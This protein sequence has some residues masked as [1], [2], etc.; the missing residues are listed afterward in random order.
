MLIALQNSKIPVL[1]ATHFWQGVAGTVAV[2]TFIAGFLAKPLMRRITKKIQERQLHDLFIDG[3]PGVDGVSQEVLPAYIRVAG[4]EE[5]QKK[6]NDTLGKQGTLL[7]AITETLSEI[8]ITLDQVDKKMTPNGGDTNEPGDLLQR[9][10]QSTGVWID[11]KKRP[12]HN[13]RRDDRA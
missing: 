5:Q 9:L 2:L 8:A 4:L 1:D 12:L 11:D 10:A 6:T 3:R 13:R 7:E